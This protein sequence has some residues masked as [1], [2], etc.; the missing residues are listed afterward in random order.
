HAQLRLQ[1]DRTA[2]GAGAACWRRH[3]VVRG[4]PAHAVTLATLH[5]TSPRRLMKK[6]DPLSLLAAGTLALAAAGAQA[7]DATAGKAAFAQCTACH[8]IDGTNGAGP[9]LKGIV[10]KKAGEGG[11]FRFSRAMKSSGV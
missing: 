1:P 2:G 8:S 6:A 11:G 5:T 3:G 7:E 10:G 4:T 9:P